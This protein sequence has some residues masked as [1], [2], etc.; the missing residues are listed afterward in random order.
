[1]ETPTIII[2][3]PNIAH[4]IHSKLGPKQPLK[5]HLVDG[6]KGWECAWAHKTPKGPSVGYNNSLCLVGEFSLFTL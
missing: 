4:F 1:M 3:V 6:Y 5:G 2:E